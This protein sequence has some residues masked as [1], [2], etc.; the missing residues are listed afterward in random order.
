MFEIPL[1]F[2]R[3]G[4]HPPDDV[5]SNRSSFYWRCLFAFAFNCLLVNCPYK[6][7]L[8]VWNLFC[9]V[10]TCISGI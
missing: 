1:I 7:S 8:K 6:D 9:I 2:E 4:W 5:M 3:G 10:I